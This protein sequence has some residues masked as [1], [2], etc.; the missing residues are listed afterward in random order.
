MKTGT[1]LKD[2]DTATLS[3]PARPDSELPRGRDSAGK[4]L[5]PRK[6]VEERASRMFSRK[7]GVCSSR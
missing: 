1:A 2:A 5:W 7:R 3:L 6:L 4:Q